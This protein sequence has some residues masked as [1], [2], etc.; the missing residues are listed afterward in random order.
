MLFGRCVILPGKT[1]PQVYLNG[2]KTLAHESYAGSTYNTLGATG[3]EVT[4]VML[5]AA[6][7]LSEEWISLLEVSGNERERELDWIWCKMY[8]R[9]VP[10]ASWTKVRCEVLPCRAGELA[11]PSGIPPAR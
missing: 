3:N 5:E 7:L 4:T 11:I 2:E 6:G 8:T 9:N 1:R 10:R